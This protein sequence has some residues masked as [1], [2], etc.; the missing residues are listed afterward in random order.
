MSTLLNDL[1]P[2]QIQAVTHTNGPLMIVAGAGTGK[3]TV[4]TRRIAWLIEQKHA[5]PEQILALTFT[6]KA[7]NEMEERVDILLPYGYVDLQISTFHSF[8]ERL[9]RDYGTQIGLT[10][11]FSL[12]T[13]LD[14]WLLARQHFDEFE[15]DY[16]RPLGNPTKYLKALL[17][18]FSRAK[19]RAISSDDY[20]SFVQRLEA[21]TD[22]LQ[23]SDDRVGELKR[24]NELASAYHKYQQILLSH[25]SF[26]FG[27]LILYAIRLLK[28]RPNVLREVR[29]RFQFVLVD[30]FQD[31][32]TAQYEFI[33][34]ISEPN[35]NIT[36]VGDDDQAI[37]K[38]RGASIENILHFE[39][40]YPDATRVVLTRNYRSSQSILDLAHTFIQNNNPNRLEAQT[41]RVL[42]KKLIAHKENTGVIDHIHCENSQQEVRAVVKKILELKEIDQ[43]CVWNDFAILV[44][45]NSAGADFA[46]ALERHNIP[47][48]FLALSG[49][50]NKSVILDVMA[51]MRVIDQPH[52]SPSLYRVLTLPMWSLSALEIAELNRFAQR[53]GK[54]LFEAMLMKK[55]ASHDRILSFM[56]AIQQTST[57]KCVTEIF[58]E[59]LKT[60]GYLDLISHRSDALK[61][62]TFGYLQQFFQRL[63]SFEGRAQHK[64]L[65]E[66][67]AEL[68]FERD[69]GEEGSIAVDL[70]A[71]PDMVRIMT[72]HGAKGLEFRYVFVVNLV[73]RKFPTQRR[74]EAIPLPDEILNNEKTLDESLNHLEEERRLFYV[75]MTRA[76]EGLFFTSAEDY[77]GARS[78]K[79][80][81]FLDEVG[82]E[83]GLKGQKGREGQEIIEFFDDDQEVIDKTELQSYTPKRFS[84][85]QLAAFQTCPLQYKFAHILRVPVLGKWTFSFGKTMHNT[86]HRY[87]LAWMERSGQRQTTLFAKENRDASKDGLPVGIDEL[88]EMYNSC[89]Q[90][91][92]Y[93]NDQT[94]EKYRKNG[95]DQ[96]VSYVSFLKE[97]PPEP[98]ALEQGYT[99][100]I[101]DIVLKGRMDRIDRFEDG[102]EI[103][104]YK[105]GSPKIEKK[106]DR[107]DKEQL[108]LYQL[109]ARDVLGLNV[110][111]LSFVYLEN[112]SVVSFLGTD[113]DLLKLQEDIVDRVARIRESHFPPTPG[114]HC[115]YC[116]FAD[117]CEFRQI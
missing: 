98:I 16:Y 61:Q 82:I 17:Q 83:K 69:A 44:R 34:M 111:K 2:E 66:F 48:Q 47:Y 101:G 115:Q 12:L 11:D 117:I 81:R 63:K 91:D 70:E 116:D 31:T 43:E 24:I 6:D 23:K 102:V 67:L 75:A 49:L 85:T 37:Y 19:D 15:L 100:K 13:E 112:N 51:L 89:W 55:T 35:R 56:N 33:K 42:S 108:W 41:E 95:K 79:L 58:L 54:S 7:A 65:N 86:L 114:F 8:C 26:D 107:F 104:D 110:K 57:T 9:L 22:S 105:T 94:R 14:S 46:N 25:D 64:T 93:P 3:T 99:Y 88:F 106:L 32:N 39:S 73:D 10:P 20:L 5:K 59:I 50:Y 76:K 68:Q 38:F 87:F 28:E 60:S 62:E 40:D 45:S 90:D 36:V 78:R 21:D 4:I 96:L 84:F 18:H 97:N 74:G 103:I 52:D 92:W 113:D 53:K 109:A 30:E 71:G 1:N 72:V 77:G 29:E 80:S 27:D